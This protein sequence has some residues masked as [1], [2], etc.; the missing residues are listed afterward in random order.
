MI[1]SH[2][3]EI[4]TETS[5]KLRDLDLPHGIILAGISAQRPLENVQVAAI[6]TLY[7]RAIRT[8][9]MPLPPADLLIVDEAHHAP[10]ATYKKIIG[11][12][13][14]A[15]LLGLT[16]TPVPLRLPRARRNFRDDD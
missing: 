11:A 7:A 4:I 6:Q 5:K 14:N 12:Y 1:I 15:T 13:P 3:R 8:D 10:A 2:R 16:A 9:R